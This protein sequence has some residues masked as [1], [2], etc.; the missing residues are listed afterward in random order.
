MK[1]LEVETSE[2]ARAVGLA[3]ALE[4]D[5]VPVLVEALRAAPVVRGVVCDE[6]GVPFPGALVV[7]APSNVIPLG[8]ASILHLFATTVRTVSDAAGRFA[9]AAGGEQTWVA[10]R[11][12]SSRCF[13]V[14]RWEEDPERPTRTNEVRLDCP[15]A[16]PTTVRVGGARSGRAIPGARVL[17]VALD[18]P[19]PSDW[20]M[21]PSHWTLASAT[22][23]D[24]GLA[25]FPFLPQTGGGGLGGFAVLA[26]T[27]GGEWIDAPDTPDV[28]LAVRRGA[29]L[30]GRVLTGDGRPVEGARVVA[31]VHSWPAHRAVTDAKGSY[32]IEGLPRT[33]PFGSNGNVV[34]VWVEAPGH[35]AEPAPAFPHVASEAERGT[36]DFVLREGVTLRGRLEG[37]RAGGVLGWVPGDADPYEDLLF[38]RGTGLAEDG[39]FALTDLPAGRV[40]LLGE[41]GD[42]RRTLGVDGLL[43][44]ETRED[45]RFDVGS[46]AR[47]GDPDEESR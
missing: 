28:R 36:Q 14:V 21:E 32:R 30:T 9:L 37:L 42:P 5:P 47:A 7:A 19:E 2:G 4:T 1:I 8:D 20:T 12:P 34:T 33:R 10:A 3:T 41:V 46:G 22:S 35:A 27:I 38:L 24:D 25:S 6:H 45:V 31:H 26:P 23:D 17:A 29:T 13:T 39:R 40:T 18:A 15:A 44:G 43:P 16:R 11:R